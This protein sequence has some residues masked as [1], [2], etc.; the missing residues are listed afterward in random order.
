MEPT[1]SRRPRRSVAIETWLFALTLT[2][3]SAL[4]FVIEPLLGKLVLPTLGATPAI[5]TTCMLFFQAALL[6]G[7]AY[8]HATAAW[9]GPRRQ[10]VV[11]VA[12]LA[13]A[14]AT[15]PVTLD[16]GAATTS[17]F[18]PVTWLL[19]ALARSAGLPFLI[20]AATAPALQ[21]W[22]AALRTRGSEDPYFLYA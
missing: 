1:G 18:T 22:F 9:L 7:Y 12:A 13:V 15:L 8:V 16:V 21:I 5:W 3:S 19:G 14:A 20:V 2:L 4:L 10:A 6:A 11:H 17:Q